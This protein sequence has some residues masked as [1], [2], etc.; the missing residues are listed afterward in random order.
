MLKKLIIATLLIFTPL[1]ALCG[2]GDGSEVFGNIDNG[3]DGDKKNTDGDNGDKKGSITD[4]SSLESKFD[5]DGSLLRCD[6]TPDIIPSHLNIKPIKMSN[7]L[8]RKEGSARHARGN[9]IRI[10]GKV[11]D[12]DCLPISNAIIKIW[13]AD[14]AG[15][16]LEQYDTKSEWQPKD[17]DYDPNFGYSG[18]AQTNNL[19]E[20]N[21]L[22]ILPGYTDKDH[23]PHINV[24][25]SNEDF[26]DIGTRIY[27]NQHPRN[28]NDPELKALA[29][30]VRKL[31]I[32]R[33][34]I[35]DQNNQYEGRV[36]DIVITLRG[37]NK[38]RRF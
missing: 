32:A 11:V 22:T 28:I 38:Y 31:V 29:P 1:T 30:D 36:Y 17:P 15:K 24:S 16:Y 3:Y 5:L 26:Q 21:F 10:R 23:A 37:L 20:F 4:K 18:T 33:G 7:N 12:E 25:I 34:K 9:Y 14:D 19:G 8:Q 6:G 35:L 27:F 13:Q 2:G